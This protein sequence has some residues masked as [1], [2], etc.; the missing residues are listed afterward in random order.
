MITDSGRLRQHTYPAG[1]WF[2][3]SG[4]ASFQALHDELWATG[5]Y[6][7]AGAVPNAMVSGGAL[8]LIPR[9]PR[10]MMD[11]SDPSTWQRHYVFPK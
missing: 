9:K 6:I 5:G 8:R 7:P 3:R 1:G 2:G 10:L 11:P 4:K